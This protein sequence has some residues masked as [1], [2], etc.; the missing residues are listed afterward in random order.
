MTESDQIPPS[1]DV[2]A[3]GNYARTK[4]G[5]RATVIYNGERYDARRHRLTR[6]TGTIVPSGR[7]EHLSLE[8]GDV[9]HGIHVSRIREVIL[10]GD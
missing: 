6:L 4:H 3:T 5:R 10:H 7:D 1:R 9:T 2:S 8:V